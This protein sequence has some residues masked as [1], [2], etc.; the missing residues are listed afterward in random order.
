MKLHNPNTDI[1]VPDGADVATA[2][3]RTTHLSICAHQDD[4]EILAYHGIIACFGLPGKWFT[5]VVVTNG[6]GSPRNGIYANYTDEQMQKVRLIEQRN[7][8]AV[9]G[10]SSQ[11]QL[12]YPS[13]T[14]KSASAAGDVREDLVSLFTAC[15]P[16]VVYMHN[17]ADKHDTHIGV[18][19]RTL[20]AMRCLPA[21]ARPKKVYGCEVWR[22]L[23]WL[24]DEE[25][26]ALPVSERPSLA[27]SLLGVFDSQI[28]GGKRYD[29][30]TAG[31]RLANATYLASHETDE[32]TELTFAMDLTPLVEDASLDITAY[33]TGYIDRFKADVE[34]RIAKFG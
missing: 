10:Y 11:L 25:K 14:V 20:E 32:E 13:S 18:A 34:S 12:G 15:R 9:G 24:G 29:L 5:G 19:L 3:S 4:I 31:R 22:A 28:S 30:A 6:A 2:L 27:A 17:L 26:V 21:E 23:D 1:Y 8:A 7:A 16:E 33:V